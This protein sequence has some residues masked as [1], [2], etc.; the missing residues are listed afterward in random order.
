M[1]RLKSI[2]GTPWHFGTISLNEDDERR[3]QSRCIHFDKDTRSCSYYR[4]HCRGSAHCMKYLEVRQCDTDA[5]KKAN[6][7]DHKINS[8]KSSKENIEVKNTSEIQ[9]ID[10]EEIA[11]LKIS[12]KNDVSNEVLNKVKNYYIE[13]KEICMPIYVDFI[14]NRLI[15]RA[16]YNIY[17]MAKKFKL[18]KI[19][20]EIVTEDQ[21]KERSRLRTPG[22]RI[23][24]AK[25]D[26]VGNVVDSIN[27]I[28]YIDFNGKVKRF[29]IY[30]F[31]EVD[32]WKVIQKVY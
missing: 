22:T 25:T 31:L 29:N 4:E 11:V 6:T 26:S 12:S 23:V 17:N 28:V 15:L 21:F 3:H 24:D 13:N 9:Y 30:K 1:T 27:E 2:S 14:G 5:I 32:R 19:P 18:K 16:N 10:I 20:V 8:L 7:Y